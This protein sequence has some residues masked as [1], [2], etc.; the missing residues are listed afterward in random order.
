ML[1]VDTNIIV[2]YVVGD[3]ACQ[4]SQARALIDGEDVFIPMSVVLE[5]EWVMRSVYGFAIA[6]IARALR[7][8]A[9]QPTVTFEQPLIVSTALG[10]AEQGLDL[11]DALHLAAARECAAFVSFDA[12]LAKAAKR[13]GALAV[14]RP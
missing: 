11:A 12:D 9:G 14:R 1:A 7:T 2:R 3:D 10:W 8:L 6:E 13:V 4:A 5:T